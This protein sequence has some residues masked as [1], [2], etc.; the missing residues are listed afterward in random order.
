[1]L[2]FVVLGPAGLSDFWDKGSG[3]TSSGGFPQL[4]E[5][6]QSWS[7]GCGP[8]VAEEA[9]HRYLSRSLYAWHCS[10]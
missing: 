10:S 6:S 7:P 1:M 8:R 2:G 4:A 5:G 3:F 9:F